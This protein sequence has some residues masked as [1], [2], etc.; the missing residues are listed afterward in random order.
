MSKKKSSG[1][2]RHPSG[3]T[4]H[5]LFRSAVELWQTGHLIKA[6]TKCQQAVKLM[7]ES[8]EAHYLLGLIAVKEGNM[9]EAAKYFSASL[10]INP[11]N[12]SGHNNLGI[13]YKRLGLLEKA[14]DCFRLAI[15]RN[16]H[17]VE[18]LVNLS[19]TLNELGEFD[20]ALDTINQALL[21]N[22]DF[23]EGHNAKGIALN[24]QGR[25]DEALACFDQALRLKPNYFSAIN[26][27]ASALLSLHQFE[28]AHDLTAIAVSLQP[29]TSEAW[30]NHGLALFGLKRYEDALA[31]LNKATELDTDNPGTYIAR[32]ALFIEIRQFEKAI[33]DL[34]RALEQQPASAEA[35]ENLAL[36]A[37]G[38]K[39][40]QTAVSAYQKLYNLH[41]ETPYIKGNLLHTKMLCCDWAETDTLA[42]NIETEL[43]EGKAAAEPF[44]YQGIGE[45]VAAL[46]ECA[47]TFARIEHPPTRT[48]PPP[49]HKHQGKITLGYICGEFRQHATSI[50]MCGVFEHH[51]KSLF[52]TIAFDAGNGDNSEY[53]RRIETAF[54]DIIDISRLTDQQ[55]ADRI[56]AQQVDILINLNG[57]YGEERLGIMALRPAPIQVSYLGFPGTLGAAYVDY[58]IAD[59]TVI[60]AEHRPYYSEQVV[61]LPDCYQANDAR[62]S[63]SD[64]PMT[65]ADFGLPEDAFVYCCF[66]NV[67]KITPTLFSVWMRILHTVPHACLWLLEDSPEASRNLRKAATTAGIESHRLHF[68]ARLDPAEHLARHQLADLFLDTLPYNAH[69]T[70]SDALWAGLPV[71]TCTGNTFP[72][73]VGT[74]L[75]QALDLNELI[76]PNLDAYE[77]Q[78][79]LLATHNSELAGI[80]EKLSQAKTRSPLFNTA[81]FTQNLEKALIKMAEIAIK[82]EKPYSFDITN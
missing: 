24:A 17:Y 58:I 73:R 69:T 19:N 77:A 78:A 45:S 53:R 35:L 3:S 39:Q 31:S 25:P 61:Y 37:I 6:K 43:L 29:G 48:P 56:R 16:N 7:P 52:R 81:L 76:A 18:A 28:Q 80:R 41:P 1:K 33:A 2:T 59:K 27:K 34:S 68:A 40:L 42:R 10:H 11:E 74:S 55:A 26:N 21:L 64:K 57:Y 72:G 79:I 82:E 22:N 75:L 14:K 44:G 70:G 65:R 63:L 66:N 36:A 13:L 9:N 32:G 38:T 12:P 62:R 20:E 15:A 71:L 51:D 54:D 49:F 5:A 46:F 4:P 23:A 8:A 30:Q 50:L 67:Y 60:P 47:R